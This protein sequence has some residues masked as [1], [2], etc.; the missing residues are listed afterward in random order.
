M[1]RLRVS[2]NK[3]Y[4]VREDGSP[5]LW[6]GDTAWHL[7]DTLTRREVD[8]YL[9]HRA[10]HGFTVI[11]ATAVMG[12]GRDAAQCSNPSNA[13]RHRP[14]VGEDEPDPASPRVVAGGTPDAPTDYWDHLDYVVRAA[15]RR[16]LYL[17]LLP[18]WGA[19]HVTG[20][21]MPASAI[22]DQYT[23]RA[24][25]AFLGARYGREPHLIWVMGGDVG[26]DEPS[27]R[28]IY[29]QM[30]GGLIEGATGHAPAWDQAHPAW[31]RLLMSYHPGDGQSSS[32]WFH[33]DA[34]L[35]FNMVQTFRHRNLLVEMVRQD[36]QRTDP[37][38]PTVMAG[39]AFE[40]YS[41]HSQVRSYP[42]QVRRQAYQSLW[43]G[44][45][46]FTY[47][48]AMS[49]PGGAGPLFGF[50]P[51]WTRLLDLEGAQQVASIWRAFVEAHAWWAFVPCPDV[52]AGR[53]E[54]EHKRCAVASADGSEL[55]IYFP[56]RTPATLR[57][58][59]GAQAATELHV[60]ATWF[61]PARGTTEEAGAYTAYASAGGLQDLRESFIPP[62]GWLDAV[63]VLT[64]R[65]Q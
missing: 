42:F 56:D 35:D 43:S 52:V 11:Q 28:R 60:Q 39:S 61:D 58:D 20:R 54:S 51:D 10:S 18:C 14:F 8:L 59:W 27:K 19:T 26:A 32:F 46:G 34:W 30:A 5:F 49:A 47:G 64:R 37:V 33:R 12:Q 1:Q 53:C 63:L 17:A 31:K 55:L 7:V 65:G 9:D 57:L 41:Q 15:R 16:G 29:R 44:A 48:C 22:F 50:G 21:V 62:S 13:Y 6:L 23:A 38:K 4:L 25:G 3:R 24:Y 40:G 36:G 2:D 45:A